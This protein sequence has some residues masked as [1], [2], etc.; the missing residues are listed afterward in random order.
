MPHTKAIFDALAALV[1]MGSRTFKQDPDHDYISRDQVM[2]LVLRIRDAA[3]AINA[4]LRDAR[5]AAA[6]LVGGA[7]IRDEREAFE[8]AMRERWPVTRDSDGE[9]ISTF[10]RGAWAGWQARAGMVVGGGAGAP[11]DL[12]QQ[13]PSLGTVPWEELIAAIGE[14]TG[15]P[16]TFDDK[17]HIGHQHPGINMNSLNRI[18][19]HF[20]ARRASELAGGAPIRM[21]TFDEIDAVYEADRGERNCFQTQAADLLR[22]FCEVNGIR[23]AAMSAA[24]DGEAAD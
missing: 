24:P 18:V 17:F 19:S 21:L 9:Y 11:T 20:I 23:L 4:A 22:K 15:A 6:E 2:P 16:P 7:P 1:G 12:Q 14:A 5:H 8:A 13:M 3:G 10:V